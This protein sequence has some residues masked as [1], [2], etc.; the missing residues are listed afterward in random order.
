MGSI[1][2][3]IVLVI[4]LLI[5]IGAVISFIN[6]KEISEFNINN[7]SREEKFKGKVF[8]KRTETAYNSSYG[9]VPSVG[10]YKRYYIIFK[11]S[12]GILKEIAVNE[13]EYNLLN[14]GYK[15]I[16]TMQGTRFKNFLKE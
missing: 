7:K 13:S 16:L 15:G 1:L 10:S 2:N 3:P 6:V 11:S 8:E 12:E 4:I 9:V 14:K 5:A